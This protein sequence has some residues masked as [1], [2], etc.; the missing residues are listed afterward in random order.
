[1]RLTRLLDTST[2]RLALIYLALFGVSALALLG[3]LYFTTTTLLERQVAETI[4]AETEGLLEQYKAQ[5]LGRLRQVIER[6]AAANPNRS[7]VYLL[8]N[9]FGL[10]SAGNL[11]TWPVVEPDAQGWIT[12]KV[13][14][15]PDDREPEQRHVRARVFLVQGGYRLLVGR[16]IEDRMKVEGMIKTTLAWGLALT[17]LLGLAG[18]L[19]MSRGL[20]GR[21]DSIN[22]TTRQII[23]GELEQRIE[24]RGSRDEFDQLAANLNAMLDQ[25][26]RLLKG[27]REV[28]DNVAHDLRTPLNRLRSRIEVALLGELDAE[29]AREL[30][31][32]T[33]AEAETMISTFNALLAI[34]RAEAGSERAP[35]E[36]V[37]LSSLLGDVEELYRPL[38]EDKEIALERR[39]ERVS[40][41]HGNR[42]LLAQAI[43]NLVDN[44]I[45]Y[46]P[47]RGR[48]LLECRQAGE[49]VRIVVA[50]DGPGV[51]ANE[52]ER[53]LERFVRLESDRS[54]AGSGLGL[55]LVRAVAR[56]HNAVLRLEDARPGLR[57]ILEFP[58][59]PQVERAA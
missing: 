31:Q 1:V 20:L 38:A 2:F 25:I 29:T 3:Y 28:S 26:E 6:R 11:D 55:S 40:A 8:S 19:I 18:G 33:L 54:T 16:E 41:V 10:R 47:S 5:G 30:L 45:K 57:A 27:M 56:L 44:A 49:K 21:I 23:A 42:E 7:S 12:F 32:Q 52:R 59:A 48:V 14:V 15:R 34:A 24:H 53:V 4:A 22:R 39:C 13:E 9:P 50:D 36:S 51:P 37:D 46:T 58:N 35:F 43:A 17:L